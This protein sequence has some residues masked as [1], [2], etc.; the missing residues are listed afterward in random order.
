[1]NAMVTRF[2]A[3][4]CLFFSFL[5][6]FVSACEGSDSSDSSFQCQGEV[7][8]NASICP[9]DDEDLTADVF[10]TVVESCSEAQFCEYQCNTGYR[11]E[12]G[13]CVP[14]D[15]KNP[16]CEATDSH[17]C[18]Y[19]APDGEDLNDG[20]FL[21]PFAST[22]PIIESLEPGDYVY[23]RGGHYG[24]ASKGQIVDYADWLPDYFS[25]AYIRRSGEEGS[26]IVFTAY[27]GE[28]PVLD[29]YH[30]NPECDPDALEDCAND[31]FHLYGA[32][33][34]RISGFE[35]VHGSIVARNSHYTWI[36]NNHIHDLLT[37]RDNN[38]LVM[39]YFTQHAYV[40]NNHLHDTYS[41]SIPDGNDGWT[42][43]ETKDHHDA[44]HN[45][46]I[47][48]LSGDIYVGY[49]HETSG[50]F[51]LSGNNI[52]DCPVHLFIKNPQGQMVDENGV[53][54]WVKDNHFHGEGRLGQHVK[55]ANI[56]FENNLFEGIPGISQMGTEEFYDEE[57]NLSIL[58]EI[59]ARNITFKNNVFTSTPS[60]ATIWGQGFILENSVFSQEMED[61]LKFHN[62]V[63]I[64]QDNAA[65]P[66]EMGWNEK[67][68]IFSNS[69]GGMID[70]DP[71]ISKT[72]SRID[73]QNNCFINNEGENI[74]FIKHW[75]NGS[76]TI[77]GYSYSD[78]QAVFGVSA[79]GDVFTPDT[80]PSHHF[81]DPQGLDYSVRSDSSCA[82]IPNVGLSDPTLF[83]N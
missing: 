50:P 83:S 82:T 32:D 10:R 1:M 47:T 57:D 22:N 69:Y 48:T 64:I 12:G 9:G 53:N 66:G 34:I 17:R 13:Q 6:L 68:F 62:N 56:L 7:S 37:D 77:T 38:G 45:G 42:L 75:F 59:C 27:P 76:E 40:R 70:T 63:V 72:L 18:F 41:R 4:G 52:H 43:N 24:K 61:K 46:C 28:L 73:S 11:F 65:T 55:A 29:M 23:F 21:H 44:Q 5:I 31:A 78:A 35:I 14:D 36:E 15:T 2:G 67:G 39:L 80:D 58:N 30:I 79:Q 51:E 74:A 16:I 19:I 20:S 54:I 81:A 33:H 25:V 60:I 3:R 8:A 49:D 71:N 26:P